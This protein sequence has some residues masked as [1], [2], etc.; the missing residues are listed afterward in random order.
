[1][2]DQ[3]SMGPI[4]SIDSIDSMDSIDSIKPIDPS[5]SPPARL[6]LLETRCTIAARRAVFLA[7]AAF[8]S[9]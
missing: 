9:P 4:D 1:M 3:K 2:M 6:Y 7:K 8:F 5:W